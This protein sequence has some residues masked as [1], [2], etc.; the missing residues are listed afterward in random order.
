MPRPIRPDRTFEIHLRVV[1]PDEVDAVFTA[2]PLGFAVRQ[3][4]GVEFP[5]AVLISGAGRDPLARVFVGGV[6]AEEV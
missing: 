1:L 6:V 3:R 4:H 5:G 2:L